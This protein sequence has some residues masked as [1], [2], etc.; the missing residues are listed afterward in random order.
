MASV[1][2]PAGVMANARAR[3]TCHAGSIWDSAAIE[4]ERL[5]MTLTAR[6][7]HKQ[8]VATWA[9]FG[10]ALRAMLPML[11]LVAVL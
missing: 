6:P 5:E 10:H 8:D 1:L 2:M 7:P 4:K 9:W 11:A 3:L